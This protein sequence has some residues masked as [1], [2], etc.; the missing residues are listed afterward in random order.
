M[1]G[2][3]IRLSEFLGSEPLWASKK[4]APKNE[5][6]HFNKV[7]SLPNKIFL[8]LFDVIDVRSINLNFNKKF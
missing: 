4:Y 5:K 1:F 8:T 3:M 7:Q 2:N 6:Q